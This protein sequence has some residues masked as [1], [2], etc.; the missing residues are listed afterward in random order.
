MANSLRNV[1]QTYW[2]TCIVC[3]IQY[4]DFLK[5]SMGGALKTLGKSL[6]SSFYS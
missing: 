6:K 5:Q 1:L 2:E 3:V 4:R